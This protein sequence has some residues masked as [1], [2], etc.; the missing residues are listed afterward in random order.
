MVRRLTITLVAA[1]AI[2]VSVEV[3]QAGASDVW[4]ILTY[5]VAFTA[6]ATR[7]F[8]GDP[9]FL[10]FSVEGRSF[11]GNH[12]S[13]GFVLGWHNFYEKTDDVIQVDNVTISGAQVR[14]LDFL[15]LLFGLN[16]H[17]GDRSSRV[18][19]YGGLKA[20]AYWVSQRVKVATVD[21]IINRGWHV[22]ASP[23]IG[24]TFLTPDLDFYGFLSADY[25]YVFT[26]S[27]D[28]DFS[29]TSVRIGFV[30]IF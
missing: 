18:R 30:Y 5:D 9:G 28:D 11:D 6:G 1:M 27:E 8:I 13:T 21:V 29:Y 19:P 16:Y 22:G 2:L 12:L 24:L 7:N 15:P 26:D 14:Y 4:G 23:E 17:F 10:G 3:H 25:N 20:G